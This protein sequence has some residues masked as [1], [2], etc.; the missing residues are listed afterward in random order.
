[1]PRSIHTRQQYEQELARWK[2]YQATK[3]PGIPSMQAA[4]PPPPKP[5]DKYSDRLTKYVP[6]E[7]VS[8]YLA[9]IAAI[10]QA[11][12]DPE[13]NQWLSE[14]VSPNWLSILYWLAFAAGVVATPIY[15]RFRLQVRSVIHLIIC[16]ASFVLWAI[17]I[18][19]GLFQ[20]WPP[21]IPAL[22]LPIYTFSV[23][24]YE[25]KSD[26]DGSL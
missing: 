21:V 17:A 26:A 9:L 20:K 12:K 15:L 19:N 2:E 4:E 3:E 8:L 24:F 25:P 14:N 16:L 13:S 18:R 7:V 11:S 6:A 22:L 10:A 23:A 1:M 5:P